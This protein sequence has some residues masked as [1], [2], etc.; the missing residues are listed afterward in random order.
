MRQMSV[1]IAAALV[2]NLVGPVLWA[3][4][5]EAAARKVGTTWNTMRPASWFVKAEGHGPVGS[6]SFVR[7]L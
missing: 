4:T 1:L 5:A 6:G 3:P 7:L 2:A